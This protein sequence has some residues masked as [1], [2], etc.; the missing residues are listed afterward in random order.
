MENTNRIADVFDAEFNK[1]NIINEKTMLEKLDLFRDRI[2]QF[3][4]GEANQV[5]I[6]WVDNSATRITFTEDE[7]LVETGELDK[8]KFN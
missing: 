8:S 4:K 6:I 7:V 5:L 1:I 3:S 2:F